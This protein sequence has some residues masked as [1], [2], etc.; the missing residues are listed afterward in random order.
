MATAYLACALV[1]LVNMA[2]GMVRLVRGPTAA[3]RVV[4][5]QLLGTVG[6]GTVLLLAAG[7]GNPALVDVAL[8][9]ALLSATT[10]IVFAAVQGVR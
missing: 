2:A 6:V 8:V 9:L 3:D 7:L 4:A 10:S 1:L 5:A